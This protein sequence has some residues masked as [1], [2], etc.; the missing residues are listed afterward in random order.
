VASINIS[1]G[2]FNA[3]AGAALDARDAGKM[4]EAR[5]LDKIARKINAAL[6]SARYKAVKF[7]SG[8]KPIRWWDVP[9]TIE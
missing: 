7:G 1:E 5:A 9:S 4:I 2:D 3:I 6:S 8:S